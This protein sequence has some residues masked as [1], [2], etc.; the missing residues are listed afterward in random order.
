MGKKLNHYVLESLPVDNIDI[1]GI[2]YIKEADNQLSIA[3]RDEQNANW[4]INTVASDTIEWGN[5]TNKPNTVLGYNITD[6][7][8]ISDVSWGDKQW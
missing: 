5:I 1:C 3:I 7:A 2:Y 6:A 8:T 4:Q